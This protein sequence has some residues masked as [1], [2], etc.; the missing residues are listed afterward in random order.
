[1]TAG[2]TTS[3]SWLAWLADQRGRPD[4]VGEVARLA[5]IGP[6]PLRRPEVRLALQ[7]ALIEFGDK[8]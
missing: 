8:A 4:A 1:M 3:R 6:L 2:A 7:V 5:A